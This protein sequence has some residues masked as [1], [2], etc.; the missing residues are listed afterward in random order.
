[1]KTVMY[2]YIFLLLII[3]SFNITVN[4]ETDKPTQTIRG[5]VTDA[6][7]TLPLPGASIVLLNI[8]PQKRTIT[9]ND[10]YLELKNVPVGRVSLKFGFIGYQSRVVKNVQLQSGKELYQ[11]DWYR[12]ELWR[13]SNN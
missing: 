2:D 1:M 11:V 7:T 9:D 10:G 4:A 5:R 12:P 13:R 6:Q 3:I 8:E